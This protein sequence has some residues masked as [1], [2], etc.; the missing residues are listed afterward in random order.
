MLRNLRN[1]LIRLPHVKRLKVAALNNHDLADA[2][3]FFQ[4]NPLP[5]LADLETLELFD[6]RL[7][8]MDAILSCCCVPTKIQRLSVDTFRVKDDSELLESFCN[9]CNLTVLKATCEF[10]A[11]QKFSLSPKQKLPPLTKIELDHWGFYCVNA[12][13]LFPTL[14][15]FGSTLTHFKM[16]SSMLIVEYPA[17]IRINLPRLQRFEVRTY[18]GIIDPFLQIPNLTHL[19]FHPSNETKADSLIDFFGFEERMY[20]SNIWEL[21]SKLKTIIVGEKTYERHIFDQM[22]NEN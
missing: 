2:E 20:E 6:T 10:E 16:T 19:K 17:A 12:E 11:F 22:Q 13:D 14:E 8:V 18:E 15:S 1:Y 7:G 4:R 9:F 3:E 21:M 5:R